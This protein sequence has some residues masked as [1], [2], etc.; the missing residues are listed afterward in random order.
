MSDA[1]RCAHCL[2]PA[3]ADSA[4]IAAE[5]DFPYAAYNYGLC[6][7]SNKPTLAAPAT[8]PAV[9]GDD[10][11]RFVE[12]GVLPSPLPRA[13]RAGW[14][15]TVSGVR[16]TH[17]WHC[18]SCRKPVHVATDGGVIRAGFD[19]KG[20]FFETSRPGR[21]ATYVGPCPNGC[22]TQLSLGT[23]RSGG[24][25]HPLPVAEGRTVL[26][27]EWEIL[28]HDLGVHTPEM[29]RSDLARLRPT[30]G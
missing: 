21:R 22:G 29:T 3:E 23:G 2:M 19:S 10:S 12:I 11:R 4:G 6:K 1:T 9:W 24:E 27:R 5:H 28:R 20:R 18:W 15:I 8:P 13:E 14:T 26:N 7:G 16:F 25:S 17:F 30:T